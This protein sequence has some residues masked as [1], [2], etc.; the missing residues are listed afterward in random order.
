MSSSKKNA[1]FILLGVL[2][3]FLSIYFIWIDQAYLT[4]FPIGLLAVFFAIYYTEYTFLSLAFLTPL[5]INIEEYTESFGLFIPTEPI[6]FGFLIL[7]LF[8]QLRKNIL[9]KEL[10]KNPIIWSV[11]FYMSWLL[12]TSITS[13]HP[14]V[15]LK[16]GLARLWFIVPVL[17]FGSYFFRKEINIKRFLWLLIIGMFLVICYTLIVHA[18]YSFGEKEGHWVMSPFFKDHTIYGA[19]VA[20]TVPLVFGLY[21]YKKH[22]PLVQVI[23]LSFIVI[24][25]LG[26]FFSYT[27]AAWLS[28]IAALGVLALIRFKIK[29]SILISIAVFIGGVIFFSWD[30][31]QM[32]LARN[33]NEHTTEDFGKKLQSAA[34]VSTDASNLERINRWSCAIEMFKERPFFGFGPGTYA[35]EYARFQDPENLT[36]IST[37]FGDLGNAHSEYLG[38]LSEM[39]VFG[40]L[41]FIGIVIAIFYKTITLYN[42]WPIEDKE[43]RILMLAM[44]LSMVTYFVHAVLNNFLDTDKAAVPIWGMCAAFIALEIALNRKI[45]AKPSLKGSNI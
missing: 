34:N 17:L 32:D 40:L 44:I 27:R 45:N 4:L 1:F 37:N 42:R 12:I 36:I 15:S 3:I 8:L 16:F 18:S 22:S 38:A 14:I 43:T 19:T 2:Y 6:L 11:C 31:I 39:G 13:S 25:L 5:S 10:W 26:M 23:L 35:F 30:A 33:K 24:I 21:L 9:P 7:F 20:L 29:L 28:L 41:S